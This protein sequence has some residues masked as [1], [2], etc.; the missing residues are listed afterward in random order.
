MRW[1]LVQESRIPDFKDSRV[2]EEIRF[3]SDQIRESVRKNLTC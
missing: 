3:A 2:T 1:C